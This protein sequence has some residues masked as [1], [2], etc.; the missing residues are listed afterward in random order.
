MPEGVEVQRGG[1]L[2]D[3]LEQ[4]LGE[5]TGEEVVGLGQDAGELRV[6]VLDVAHGGIDLR[7]DVLGF[8]AVEQKIES[9][10]GGQV[11]DAL[12]V[13]SGGFIHTAA[14]V[15]AVPVP[16]FGAGCLQLGTLGGEG[17]FGEAQ[18]NAAEDG[19][20]YSWD[21]R[22][23]LA[24]NWSAAS[25]SRFSNAAVSMSF[26]DGAIQIMRFVPFPVVVFAGMVFQSVAEANTKR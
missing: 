26:S 12:G 3:F 8:E 13:V 25:R 5:G 20:E 21:L 10:L 14:T 1:N 7:T 22:R 19:T 24:R 6:V 4:F 9:R 11:K 17:D 2:G 18:K 15:R 16:I 23:K